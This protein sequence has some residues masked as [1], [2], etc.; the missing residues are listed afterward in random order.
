MTLLEAAQGLRDG[1]LTSTDLTSAAIQRAD[2]LDERL[3]VYLSRFD[4][5]AM[6]AAA[7]ADEDLRA[8]RDTGPLQGIPFGVKDILAAKEGPTTAQSLVLDRAW[9]AGKDAVS[10]ARLRE[11]GAV[12]T[13]KLTTMEFAGGMPESAKPFPFPRNPWNPDTWPGGSS[14]G[15]GVGVAAG[16][17]LAGLGSDTGGSIRIPAAFCGVSGLMP[18]FGLVPK[19]GCVPFGYS[20]DHIGPL[21]RSARDCAAVLNVVAG[22]DATDPSSVDR[23]RTDYTADLARSLHG[24]RLG[25]D[26]VHHMPEGADPAA[27][28]RFEASIAT[29][30]ELGAGVVEISLPHY[31]EGVTATVAT[32]SGE[33]LTYHR[34]DL[35]S[36]WEDYTSGF[37]MVAA[38][39][40]LFSAADFVQAQR[41]RR[42]VM[43]ELAKMLAG[44]D[45]LVMP[46]CTIGSPKYDD[47]LS[48]GS[49]HLFAWIHTPYWDGLGNPV[50]SVPMGFT[51]EGLPLGL[52]IAGKPFDET[53]ILRVGNALQEVTDWHLQLPPITAEWDR[54]SNRGRPGTT[55]QD[56]T[57]GQCQPDP[58]PSQNDVGEVR[59]LLGAAGLPATEAEVSTLAAGMPM[60]RAALQALWATDNC[61]Y[62]EPAMFFRADP[63]LA[64][65][66]QPP[67]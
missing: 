2:A 41:V 61:R 32:M 12:I 43:K 66:G 9:G 67:P 29:L 48:H 31:L 44:L 34:V 6:E 23:P 46:T 1:S 24:I 52:Q 45:A 25:V 63:P 26:R 38:Q 13:G 64:T 62:E 60:H 5:T 53:T 56:S 58:A 7:R 14:S 20:L 36:R 18:T 33:A 35:E 51:S 22:Y 17:I 55:K 30:E 39:G 57:T 19:S 49:M 27:V 40:A 8:G 15:T 65:W 21:A 4:E 3:G 47:V 28:E 10:V 54:D 59:L 50:L 37:R 16:L 42:V 11:A